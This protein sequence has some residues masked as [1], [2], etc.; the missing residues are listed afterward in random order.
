[1][2]PRVKE[3]KAIDDY[4]LDII[5]SSGEVGL[6]DCSPLLDFGVFTEL[7]DKIIF[8]KQGRKMAL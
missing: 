4:K 2:N 5:F 7:K 3:V 8:I 1:M 6:Y